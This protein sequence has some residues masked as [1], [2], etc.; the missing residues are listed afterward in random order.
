MDEFSLPETGSTQ[1]S[2]TSMQLRLREL[3][4]NLQAGN[5]GEQVKLKKACQDFEAVFIGQ[6]WKQ[7]RNSTHLDGVEHSKEEESYTSMFDQ[8]FSVKMAESGGIGLSRM[9]YDNLSQRL[10]TASHDTSS[11]KPLL[12][13]DRH[14]MAKIQPELGHPPGSAATVATAAAQQEADLLARQIEQA[15]GLSQ[16]EPPAPIV[17]T[18][19]LEDALR[20]VSMEPRSGI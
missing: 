19:A 16:P 8:E 3:R 6:I 2:A 12:P 9:L 11:A 7:M 13:L 14:E 20:A 15:H 18:S 10:V 4:S 1:D 17:A 5:N